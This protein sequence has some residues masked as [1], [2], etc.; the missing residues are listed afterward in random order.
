MSGMNH[1]AIANPVAV[2]ETPAKKATIAEEQGDLVNRV[3]LRRESTI[4]GTDRGLDL[5]HRLIDAISRS[6]AGDGRDEH[7]ITYSR[8]IIKLQS[9]SPTEP[10]AAAISNWPPIPKSNL[11]ATALPIS[12]CHIPAGVYGLPAST[13]EPKPTL[14]Q[15]SRWLMDGHEAAVPLGEYLFSSPICT[16]PSQRAMALRVLIQYWSVNSIRVSEKICHH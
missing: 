14:G 4:L 9:T 3:I 11:S 2:A 6:P 5:R 8:T 15:T 16:T 13:V 10:P 1:I 7:Q 12:T